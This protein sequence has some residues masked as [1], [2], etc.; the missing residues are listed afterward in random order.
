MEQAW[1]IKLTSETAH[2]KRI[3]YPFQSF[4]STKRT[5]TLF[6]QSKRKILYPFSMDSR[7]DSTRRH[8]SLSKPKSDQP[9]IRN[10]EEGWI[11]ESDLQRYLDKFFYQTFESTIRDA[12]GCPSTM[13]TERSNDQSG[14]LPRLLSSTDSSQASGISGLSGSSQQSD[15]LFPSSPD[16]I[17][18]FPLAS[19][20]SLPTSIEIV[21]NQPEVEGQSFCR[22][23]IDDESRNRRIHKRER[24]APPN[25]G[26]LRLDR[27]DDEIGSASLDEET[28]FGIHPEFTQDD[29]V[30]SQSEE[31]ELGQRSETNLQKVSL[32][33]KSHPLTSWQNDRHVCRFLSS[34]S[35]HEKPPQLHPETQ[36][37][38]QRN[39]QNLTCSDPRHGILFPNVDGMERRVVNSTN[40]QLLSDDGRFLHRLGSSLEGRDGGH[41]FYSRRPLDSTAVEEVQS[42]GILH[43]SDGDRSIRS[44][45]GQYLTPVR[46][47]PDGEVHEQVI[48]AGGETQLGSSSIVQPGDEAEHPIAKRPCSRNRKCDG[49]LPI[50]LEPEVGVDHP[51]TLV[52]SSG[53]R[54]RDVSGYLCESTDQTIDLLHGLEGTEERIL[55]R[56]C[57]S[58][59]MAQTS[60]GSTT[61]QTPQCDSQIVNT[62]AS[63]DSYYHHTRMASST[64]VS[65]P[66]SDARIESN[67]PSENR[68]ESS[69]TESHQ[70]AQDL[71]SFIRG[72]RS[73]RDL[74]RLGSFGERAADALMKNTLRKEPKVES[75]WRSYVAYLKNHSFPD[76][77]SVATITDYMVH[78]VKDQKRPLVGLEQIAGMIR[79]VTTIIGVFDVNRQAQLQFFIGE[80]IKRHTLRP[81]AKKG[82]IDMIAILQTIRQPLPTTVQQHEVMM[83]AIV[84]TLVSAITMWRGISVTLI[85]EPDI[86]QTS[87]N[88]I[89]E[90]PF[91]KTDKKFDGR[92]V[93]FKGIEDNGIDPRTWINRYI[94][95]TQGTR[96]RFREKFPGSVVPLFLPLSNKPFNDKYLSE[97]TISNAMQLILTK[98]NQTV[99]A[100]KEKIVPSSW[101]GTTKNRL[102]R[103]SVPKDYIDII[104]DWKGSVTA[105]HY[106]RFIPPSCWI[107][108]CLAQTNAFVEED[109]PPLERH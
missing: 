29:C 56:R 39:G 84:A 35:P 99:D 10:P 66:S 60:L 73:F 61:N 62:V 103:L 74:I 37:R 57:P 71:G 69:S 46:Q 92:K 2:W 4:T 23:P 75:R 3:S 49:G 50:S 9:H 97:Q 90:I 18:L 22:R 32:A 53:T 48:W 11:H 16:G 105:V 25:I 104:G 45:A 107:P 52:Q 6:T 26:G 91:S 81:K 94:E 80:Y 86:S 40:T 109:F 21:E 44:Q 17:I 108:L 55:S 54:V 7:N 87:L 76:P 65:S 72:G 15:L 85:S 63:G 36:A 96:Q 1:P 5:H 79:S 51:S 19:H 42:L 34:E 38:E 8:T 101:R 31:E 83:R 24:S 33:D 106:D 43:C 30:N 58:E 70:E 102:R 13:G 100:F 77:L 28:L 64:M 78:K 41:S 98:A 89:L 95:L 68:S 27:I 82:F 14:R 20:Q 67:D 88:F 93:M 12:Q 59:C 47:H